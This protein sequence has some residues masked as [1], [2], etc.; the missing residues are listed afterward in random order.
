MQEGPPCQTLRRTVRQEFGGQLGRHPALRRGHG[1]GQVDGGP[2]PVLPGALGD[3]AV[4]G[5]EQRA[6]GHA[7]V[8]RGGPAG[9]RRQVAHRQ[10]QPP[11]GAPRLERDRGPVGGGA[12]RAGRAAARRQP[13]RHLLVLGLRPAQLRRQLIPF[14]VPISH[15][16]TGKIQNF[17]HGL[18]AD[19]ALRIF[20][21]G[22]SLDS[23]ISECLHSG[24]YICT[25]FKGL[26]KFIPSGQQSLFLTT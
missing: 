24:L 23:F 18:N 6:V 16:F 13:V 12:G 1:R 4:V 14:V 2:V 19:A 7:H 25:S 3:Q 8:V 17:S 11:A 10:R 9:A 26:L 5:E 21:G 15:L 22:F 20:G